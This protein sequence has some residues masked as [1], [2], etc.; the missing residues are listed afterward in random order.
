MTILMSKSLAR[1]TLGIILLFVPARLYAD[2]GQVQ[3]VDTPLHIGECSVSPGVVTPAQLGWDLCLRGNAGAEMEL[4]AAQPRMHSWLAHGRGDF[5][6]HLNSILALHGGAIARQTTLISDP[7]FKTRLVDTEYMLLAIGNPVLHRF[8]AQLGRM[9]LPF[10]I[11][12]SEAMETVR[13][14]EHR[15]FWSSPRFGG[16]LLIDNLRTTIL[17]IGIA[18]DGKQRMTHKAEVFA[19]A[20]PLYAEVNKIDGERALS[21]RLSHDVSLLD[22]SKLVASGYAAQS[23]LRRYGAGFLTQSNQGDETHFEFVRIISTP[24]GKEDQFKQLLRASYVSTWRGRGRWILQID[25]EL[26]RYRL[27]SLGYDTELAKNARLRLSLN[28]RRDL[29]SQETSYWSLAAGMEAH[30]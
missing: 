24:D 2:I 19:H 12:G 18:G 7:Q 16:V 20:E 27:G 28:F 21:L 9:I 25:D 29:S 3:V 5:G 30:L 8:R 14:L 11:N 23:G 26:Q 6:L 13:V 4:V 10:G 1:S 17:E 22:G 15:Y